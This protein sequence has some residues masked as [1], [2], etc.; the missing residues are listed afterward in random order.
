MRIRFHQIDAF[1]DRPFTG[2]PAAVMLLD[3]PLDDA[4]CQSIAAENNI[5]ETAFLV[6]RGDGIADYDLR[7]FTPAV[8]VELCGH[9]TLASGHWALTNDRS[10]GLSNCTTFTTTMAVRPPWRTE[11]VVSPLPAGFTTP[12]R[13]T[14]AMLEFSLANSAERP[15]SGSR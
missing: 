1:A 8:E 9:A 4:V 2:N 5:A 7:W 12:F 11:M 15:S 14:I 13:S 6:P 10:R 3:T